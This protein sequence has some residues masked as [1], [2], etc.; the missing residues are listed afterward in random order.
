[1]SNA[2]WRSCKSHPDIDVVGSALTVIDGQSNVV[3]TR[4]YPTEHEE[5]VS[6]MRRFNPIANSTVMFRREVYERFG[7]WRD[8]ALPAQDYEWYSRLA[9]GGARFANLEEPLVRYRLHGGSIKSSKLRGTIQTTL[10]VKNLYWRREMDLRSRAVCWPSDCCCCSGSAGAEVVY[11][12]SLSIHAPDLARTAID[13]QCSSNTAAWRSS[14]KVFSTCARPARPIASH[15][16][17]VEASAAMFPAIARTSPS[18]LSNPETPSS[19]TSGSPLCR[20]V[21]IGSPAAD[22]SMNETP[23]PSVSPDGVVSQYCV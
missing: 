4:R 15:R 6:A 3:G 14:E 2:S 20:V 17:G 8:S 16:S 9:A 19:T 22:A 18:A 1:M 21:A 23:S 5:I 13:R 11:G 7:G 10:E 12:D